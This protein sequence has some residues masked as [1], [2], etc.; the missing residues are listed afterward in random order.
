VLGVSDSAQELEVSGRK[1]Q[2]NRSAPIAFKRHSKRY[3]SRDNSNC[4][5]R[6]QDGKSAIRHN[7]WKRW[8]DQVELQVLQTVDSKSATTKGNFRKRPLAARRTASNQ[9]QSLEAVQVRQTE[10]IFHKWP[11]RREEEQKASAAEP[12]L[13]STAA[14]AAASIY[15]YLGSI[16]A[17]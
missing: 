4:L 16:L 10:P 6:T 3:F 11:V 12:R 7:A 8:A 13:L 1:V 17:Y 15:G 2:D 5:S 14:D 9:F